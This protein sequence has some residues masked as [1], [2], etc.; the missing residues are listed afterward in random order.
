MVVNW[1]DSCIRRNDTIAKEIP[2]ISGMTITNGNKPMNQ[3]ISSIIQKIPMQSNSRLKS[4]LWKYLTIL[5]LA[6]PRFYE[7]NCSLRA[8]ALALYSLLSVVPVMALAF[9][10]AKG[11]GFEKMLEAQLL[12]NIPSQE[13]GLLYIIDF[14]RTLLENTQGGIIAGIGV[15]FLL[16]SV[17]RVLGNIES[18]FNHIWKISEGRSLSRKFS[19]YFSMTLIAPILMIMSSS[20]SVFITTQV[21]TITKSAKLIEVFSPLIFSSIRGTIFKIFSSFV[22]DI[23][24]TFLIF[25]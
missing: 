20:I 10:I 13:Q 23:L 6:L 15:A 12:E 1:R 14:A 2:A 16:W 22:L 3:I 9:G 18:S 25:R 7:D 17:I 11:F 21:T 19:D 5:R 4:F 24:N 8:S